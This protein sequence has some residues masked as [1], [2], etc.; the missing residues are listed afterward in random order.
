MTP[1]DYETDREMLA[2]ALGTIGLAEPGN[3]RLLWI[4]DTLHLGEVE[5]SAA[6]LRRSPAAH[7]PGDS[8]R[9]ARPA[10]RR[11]GQSARL[12]GG[13]PLTPAHRGGMMRHDRW[14][15]GLALGARLLGIYS[16]N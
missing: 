1:L 15:A 13:S 8:H 9:T 2:A 12:R 5:C 14:I 4:A 3:A 16:H 10:V 6:Y 11:G 7:G